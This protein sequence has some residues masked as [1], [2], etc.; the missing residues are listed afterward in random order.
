MLVRAG[1]LYLVSCLTPDLEDSNFSVIHCWKNGWICSVL[2]PQSWIYSY[3]NSV[4]WRWDLRPEGL[5]HS[6]GECWVWIQIQLYCQTP[7]LSSTSYV[8]MH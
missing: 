3:I 1:P 5:H 8:S 4:R 6:G 2:Y 7:A